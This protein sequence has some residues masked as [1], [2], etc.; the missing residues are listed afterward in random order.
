MVGNEEFMEKVGSNFS[1]AFNWIIR[2][3][4]FGPMVLYIVVKNVPMLRPY[5]EMFE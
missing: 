2:I 1:V 4:V 3:V 5:L